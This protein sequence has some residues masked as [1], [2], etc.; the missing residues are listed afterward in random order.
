MTLGAEALEQRGICMFR[1]AAKRWVREQ[2][3]GWLEKRREA[4]PGS[5]HP[6][7]STEGL[8][9]S[10]QRPSEQ[11]NSPSEP[12][13]ASKPAYVLPPTGSALSHEALERLLS[14]HDSVV[15]H[16]FATW[17]D[18]CEEEMPL[19][20]QLEQQLPAK[21]L[22]LLLSWDR[23]DGQGDPAQTSAEVLRFVA[24]FG[25]RAPAYVYTGTHE[26]LVGALEL[27]SSRIPQTQLRGPE[28]VVHEDISR[29][30]RPDDLPHMLA[31]MT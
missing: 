29:P 5:A 20:R 3:E 19:V 8:E 26:L 9:M 7:A 12:E 30:L 14:A 23:F 25:L 6:S 24:R 10:G 22:L 2:L 11:V 18:P 27:G 28:G 13:T 21:T 1:S 16:H 17:C 15:L 4:R 31:L